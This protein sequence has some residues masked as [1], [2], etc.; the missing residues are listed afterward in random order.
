MSNK[1]VVMIVHMDGR[2]GQASGV[3]VRQTALLD[4]S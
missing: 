1:K 4:L 2:G 3:M